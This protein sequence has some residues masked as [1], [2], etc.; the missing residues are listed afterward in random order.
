MAFLKGTDS[1]FYSH[2]LGQLN[3]PVLY[4][5]P[6][7]CPSALEIR[8][9]SLAWPDLVPMSPCDL[10]ITWINNN[11]NDIDAM[12]TVHQALIYMNSLNSPNSPRS[13]VIMTGIHVIEETG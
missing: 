5:G 10:R 3:P 11:H 9:K 7:S 6:R 8:E 12:L 1:S 13:E 4:E 2:P